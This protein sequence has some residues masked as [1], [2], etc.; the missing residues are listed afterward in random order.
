M[1]YVPA[2][3]QHPW[4]CF[5]FLCGLIAASELAAQST[6]PESTGWY[7]GDMHVHRSCGGA[8]VTVSSIMTAMTNRNLAVI[9]LLADSGNG[10]VQNPITDLPLVNG[11]NDPSSTAS[12]IIHW[13]SEW[14]WDATYTQYPFQ[15]LG[16]HI[17]LLGLTSAHQIID[18]YTYP[19]FQFAHQQGAIAGFAHLQYLD[20]GFPSVLNCCL[21]IEYPVEVALGS[22]D[23][24]S[25]DVAGSDTAMHAYYRLL[26]CGFRPG[27]AG[28]SDYPCSANIGD[29]ITYVNVGSGG[30]TYQ[31]WIAG[32]KSGHTVVSRNSHNEFL[33]LK[34]NS[35]SGPGDEILLP[36]GGGNVQVSVQWTANQSLSGTIEL[37]RNGVVVASLPA[38]VAS[39][40]SATLTATV[41]VPVSSWLAARRMDSNLGH[42]VQTAAMFVTVNGAPVRASASDANFYVAWMS[43]LLTRTSPGGVWNSYF[44][45]SLA[46][47]QARYTAAQ[48]VFQQIAA[49]SPV[50]IDTATLNDG[51]LNNAYSGT[52]AASGGLTPYTWSIVSGTLPTGLSLNTAT[53]AIT[54]IPTATGTYNFS[55]SVRD[56]SSPAQSAT[57]ALSIKITALPELTIWATTAAPGTQD[58]GADNPVELG[59]KFRSDVAGSVTGIRFYKAST[60]TGTHVGNLW[61]S[62]GTLLSSATFS[63]ETSS[64]WQQVTFATPVPIAANTVYVASYFCPNGHYSADANYF[65]LSGVDNAPLH[66]LATGVSG[67]NSVYSYGSTSVFPSQTWNATNYWVDISFAAPPPPTLT[68]IAITPV[69]PTLAPGATLQLTA[70]G[71]YSD[72]STQNITSQ[73][74]WSSGNVSR[75]TVS[76]GGLVTG[77]SAGNGTIFAT[78]GS[79]STT[80]TLTLLS[81]PLGISTASVPVGTVGLAYSTTLAAS[82][83]TVPYTWAIS[84]GTLPA[85]LSLNT[86]TGAITGTPT[87]AGTSNFTV[88]VSD[89]SSPVQ[90]ATTALSLTVSAPATSV[91]IWPSTAVPSLADGGADSPVELG[92][93]FRSDVAGKITSI[94][95]YKA[96]TNTGTHV[97][98]LWSSTG[99]LLGSATFSG[100]TAS[101]WQQVNF[102]SPVAIAANTVYVASY[103]VTGG[104][105]SADLNYFASVGV[106]NAPL[107]ALANGVSGG[108]GVYSYGSTSIFPSLT[109][110]TA[111]YWVDVVFQATVAPTLLSI[112][113]TPANP[114]VLV[115]GTQQFTATGTYSDNSTQNLTS[116][117]TWA[118]SATARATISSAGLATG[119]SAGTTTIS[120]ALGTISGSTTLT[121]QP[122]P[123]SITTASLANGTVS[124]AYSATLAASGGTSPYTWSLASGALPAGL[125]LNAGTGAITGTPTAPGT[126]NFTVKVTDSGSPVQN[127]TKALSLTVTTTLISIAVTPANPTVLVAGTQQFAATGTYSDNSTQNLTSQVTWASSATTRATI[128][129]AG[130]ATGVSAG[131]T[132]ISAT[133]GAI[134]G[135]T[136][137]TVQPAPL[138]ITTASLANGTVGTAYSATLAASGGTSPFT[139]SLASGALPAGLTLGASTGAIT[140]T[141]TAAG[142]ASFTVQVTDSGSPTQNATKA[143]T[144]TTSA[145]VSSVTIWPS[146]AVP[147]L[148]DGGADNPVEL[149]VKFRSDVAGTITSIRFYKASTNTG[150]HVGNLWSS[151]GTLLASA[152]FSGET[153]SGWQQVNFSSPVAIAA[154]TVYVASYHA[155]IGHYSA[156]LN[157]FASVGVDNAPLHAL[158][159]GVSG[160]DGVYNYSPVSVFPTLTWS[161]ANY[162]VD[163]VFQAAVA[164]T[165]VSIA[166]TP[167][168]PTVIVGGAQ[169]FTATGTYSDNSTQNLTS[170]ATWASSAT[171]RATISSAGLATGVSTGT[172]TI[173]AALGTISGST[174]LTVQPAPLSIATASLANGTVGTAYSATLAASGGTSPYTWSLASGTLPAGLTLNTATGAITGTPTATGTANF[175]VKV[176]DSGSPVQSATK[177]LTLTITTTLT[178]IAV[179]PANPTVLVA[180]TQQFT[181][182]G[183]YSDS[184]TQNLTS[185]VTW[186]SSATARATINAAGLATGVSAGTTTISAT[187]GAISGSTTLTVQPAPLSISTASLANGTVG[188]AYSAAL[189]ASGGTTPYTWSIASG[190]LPA[191]LALNASTGAI[192]GTPTAAGTFAF[193]AKATDSGSPAQNATKSLNITVVAS[194]SVTIWP[195]TA[196]PNVVDGGVD[197]PVELGVKFRSDVAGTITGI[198]FYKGGGN[199]GYHVGNLWSS[200]GTLLASAVFTSETGS[201]WQQVNFP[202]AVAIA[203]NT[204]YVASYHATIH[205]SSDINYFTSS[206]VD[207]PPLHALA[208]GVSGGNGLYG[209]G[210]TSVFPSQSW[211]GSNYWVDVVFQPAGSPGP[212]TTPPTVSA[213]VPFAGA[214]NVAP[215]AAAVV[216]FSEAMNPATITTST[217]TLRDS[218]NNVV[219]SAVS[220][221]S[222]TDTAQLTP[223][224]SLAAASTYTVTVKGGSSGV[225]DAAGN[226]L[227]TDYSWTFTTR[228]ADPYGI[229][230]GGPI[231][232]ITDPANPFT[233]YLAEILL[234]EGINSFALQDIST[235]TSTTLGQYDLAILGQTTLTSAQ[236]AMFTTWVNAGGNLIAMRPDKQLASLLG[237]TD[238]GSTLSNEYLLVNSASGP[239]SGIVSSS[240]IQF[241]GTADC[242]TLGAASSVATLYSNA[243]TATS[244]PA[245][246]L[247]TVGSSGGHAAAFTFDLPSSIVYTRQGNPAWSGEERDGLTPIRSDDMY[248]GAAAFDPEP[249]WVDLSRVAIPQADEQQRLLANMII[250]MNAA[251]RPLPRFN[252]FPFGYQAVIVMTGDDHGNGG[253][254]GRFDDYIAQ[255]PANSSVANWTA[256]RSSSNIYSVPTM[257]AATAASYVA[258]GF[259]ISLH[260]TTDE[261]DYTRE[262]VDMLLTNQLAQFAATYPSLPPPTTE[263]VHAIAWSSYSTMAEVELEH[264]IRLDTSYY[265]WPGSWIN[266]LPGFMTG[267][268]MP[269]RF[270][271]M[272]GTS[273][274]VYQAP[275]QMTDESGQTYP[276]T[277][278]TLLDNALGPQGYYGAF[279][280]NM[281][282]DAVASTGSD[283]IIQSALSRGVPVISQ[284]QLLTWVDAR[285]GSSFKSIAWSSNTLSFTVQANANANGLLAMVPVP[286][287]LM[288]SNLRFNGSSIAYSLQWIKGVQYAVF[289]APT[290]N[291]QINLIADTVAPTVQSITPANGTTGVA[292]APFID[293]TFSEA[294]APATINATTITLKDSLNNSVSATVTYDPTTFTATLQ[295]VASLK[296]LTNYVVTVTAGSTGVTDVAGNPLAV[297]FT[298]SFTTQ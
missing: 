88:Q 172:T 145:P 206:G 208:T 107:H 153:A 34:V 213:V 257:D 100:E 162:W 112:A 21:P 239:G 249:D 139:W 74:T 117:V 223:T 196:V 233:R 164:P 166:V 59:V 77:V 207:N 93:K 181:A 163:V 110:S 235:V 210:A 32:I 216:G 56:S 96:S 80:T 134:S 284:K 189:A 23:F 280:A 135:S 98:N 5:V 18:E 219:P 24:I 174:T 229:G 48:T 228:G 262:S 281:H 167:A 136:T 81:T 195:T 141:P 241:H 124:T 52:L 36:A 266:N 276:F 194:A 91:T 20:D 154:N 40:T 46:Q 82:G 296:H 64:G 121:V 250:Q 35:T 294:M 138:S 89:S 261:A 131:T 211:S 151:T 1:N 108:N 263:R 25:E 128:S 277:V 289:S 66:A 292:I 2:S 86:S 57:S 102:S 129:S 178:S 68:S 31:K 47:A 146:T 11:Q 254:A 255:S 42:Q 273:L 240:T 19:I 245:V 155:T 269:M 13:D 147:S 297:K 224:S 72:N 251:K 215:G 247:R 191:G 37:V 62:T 111:N 8:P 143:L 214:T 142:T 79:V 279:V 116:Q 188:T 9:S 125:T 33:D 26:N 133:S 122:A 109:W 176:T 4:R 14:H 259:D 270:A 252:Y 204:V 140:G 205:Y 275:T 298:S 60:N 94:R 217:I 288:A 202:V 104:H 197:N 95:F 293:I 75:A 38:S 150:T 160:G 285:N 237:L 50:G 85:G 12:N 118:S 43:Q 58:A 184:S 83:G 161:T 200:T 272:T 44:P 283:A 97:G 113:V 3:S 63:G 173:S 256:I 212:D 260:L 78:L 291:Y 243:Q 27:W 198:R 199:A 225:A 115:A 231:L 61:S 236:V 201:G 120:A 271:T 171:A 282:T 265:Y 177:A 101:G 51:A 290:G 246:T 22:C 287:G 126:A 67:P 114:T 65:T 99:T 187:S 175:T 123:L 45:T 87:A 127:V 29:V 170:Q 242:Y 92:V 16:G 144:L 69:N 41:N 193:T 49:Q 168:N 274:D 179:T 180:S 103:H 30:L 54:G 238:A 132:T 267:S 264:G 130:L 185:Q 84:V 76:A 159:N 39:G 209:Y 182:T 157:Y 71:T 152:T 186:A 222:S 158:A 227:S 278:D 90:S 258:A 230:P 10:E 73:V 226:N 70:T 234:A 286:A 137:L 149:G 165:L 232:V 53:G 156:D 253:T 6:G 192:T 244:N 148:I 190:A 169:Q 119:V 295:P 106:D 248:F 183:T 218:S 15:A 221:S 105:Y 203:A 268:G 55:V 7:S 220:Y 17:V 28:G